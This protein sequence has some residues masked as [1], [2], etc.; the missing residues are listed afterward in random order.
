MNSQQ[1]QSG[2]DF[3]PLTVSL[4]Q[5]FFQLGVFY[6]CRRC[7]TTSSLATASMEGYTSVALI[8][9]LEMKMSS[10]KIVCRQNYASRRTATLIIDLSK[11]E[12]LGITIIIIITIFT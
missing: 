9:C 7:F 8:W 6:L 1:M 12:Y 10:M 2:E 3:Y 4:S 11:S 5:L